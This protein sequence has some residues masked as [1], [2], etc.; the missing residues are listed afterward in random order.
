MVALYARDL[1]LERVVILR[2]ATEKSGLEAESF[3][4]AFEAGGGSVSRE[5]VYDPAATFF[6]SEFQQVGSISPD[7]LFLP[8]T[9]RDIQLLAPQFTFFGLDTLGI[10]LLGTDG[11]AEEE[12]VGEVDSRH[13]DGVIA[14]TTRS[15]QDETPAFQRFREGYENLFQKTLRSPVPA[16]GFDAAALVL[17]A[18]RDGPSTPEELLEAMERI[19]DFPGATGRLS[20]SGGR[21]LRDPYLVR[22]QDHELIYITPRFD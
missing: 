13:T 14:S 3:R 7:G 20:I 1:G 22:I 4:E 18:L 21:I 11:W 19:Q 5:I 6:Q 8:L 10:Q 9:P 16:Y 2:P 17:T 15:S 12:V